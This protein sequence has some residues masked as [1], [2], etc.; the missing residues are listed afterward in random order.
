M[1]H[2]KVLT[3]TLYKWFDSTAGLVFYILLAL[4]ST[5]YSFWWDIRQACEKQKKKIAELCI[6]HLECA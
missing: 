3:S 2:S 5:G 4:V 6:L 1:L